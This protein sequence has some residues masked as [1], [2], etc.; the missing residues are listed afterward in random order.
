VGWGHSADCTWGAV[1]IEGIKWGGDAT[2]STVSLGKG[3]GAGG[4]EEESGTEFSQHGEG[5][6]GYGTQGSPQK[7]LS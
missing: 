1:P 2:V 4:R 5:G 6:K 7:K 3:R